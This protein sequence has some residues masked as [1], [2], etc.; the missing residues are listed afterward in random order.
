MLSF[1]LKFLIFLTPFFLI[2]VYDKEQVCVHHVCLTSCMSQHR[3]EL[4]SNVEV[5]ARRLQA[6][7][8]GA[9]FYKRRLGLEF[10]VIDN[11]EADKQFLRIIFSGLGPQLD[12]TASFLLAIDG[13]IYSIQNLE[14]RVEGVD[15]LLERLNNTNEFSW[16]VQVMRRSFQ[17]Y[18]YWFPWYKEFMPLNSIV[19]IWNQNFLIIQTLNIPI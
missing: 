7:T 4:R 1:F 17:K 10:E 19:S 13:E 14:P 16:F 3:V 12:Q 2:S 9:L 6:L 5:N 11:G 8:Q 15:A 18:F